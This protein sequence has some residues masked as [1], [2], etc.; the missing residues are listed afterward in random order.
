MEQ[1]ITLG[2]IMIDCRDAVELQRFYGALLGWELD[3]LLERTI[4]AMR[5]D[6]AAIA[7]AVAN[8]E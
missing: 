8:L 1:K 7:A 3:T 4:R 2:N 5:V 6:E